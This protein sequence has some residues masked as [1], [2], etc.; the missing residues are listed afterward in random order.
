MI[1]GGG[2]R[3]AAD[4]DP[5]APKP[6]DEAAVKKILADYLR[7]NPGA[8]MPSG[9]QT[10]LDSNRGFFIRSAPDPKYVNWDD[11]SKIPFELRIRGRIQADYYYYKTT[12]VLNHQ[13]GA[14]ANPVALTPGRGVKGANSSPDF[15]QLMIKRMRLIFE[16]TA[17]DPNLRY[18]IQIDGQ[19][20]G[21]GALAGGGVPTSNGLNSTGG[22]PG[23]GDCNGV[24]TVDHALRLFSAY[25]AYDMHPC[26]YEKGCGPDCPD[27]T[28]RY[29]PT[30]TAFIGKARP[31]VAFEEYLGSNNQQFVEYGMSNWFFD[32]DDD[33]LMMM[34]GTQIKALD[35]RLFIQAVVTNGNETQIANLQMDDL[36]GINI[37]GWYDFGGSWNEAHKRWD[38]F[39]DC[40]SD[41]DYS[42][43]PVLRVG[44]AV[45]VVPMDRRSEFTNAEL[46]RVRVVQPGPGG[47]GLLGEL[48]GGGINNNAAGI[49]QFAVDAFDS[50]TCELFGPAN[51]AASVC[52]IAGGSA[53]STTSAAAGCRS[54][55]PAGPSSRATASTRPSSTPAGPVP[56]S[57]RSTPCST[58]AC[59]SRPATSSCRRSW[60]CAP[61]G[62]TSAT[63]AATSTAARAGRSSC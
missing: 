25:I 52:I 53:T 35:D 31:M 38:L 57:S 3:P 58:T 41:V 40:L 39:G 46:N 22:V 45:N 47:T 20:R 23:V 32:A 8:G 12:D 30:V 7:D 18:H 21:I 62:R 37:G 17:F 48:G 59:S 16:G 10:G 42:C 9:V 19:T 24:A 28:Y 55:P 11:G 2:V 1:R 6:L 56:P 60:K 27:V 49:G 44:G 29:T 4:A 51:T 26:G 43:K 61:A 54:T 50:Y 63:R 14:L 36:P 13:T 33:N 15:S 5:A 34:A